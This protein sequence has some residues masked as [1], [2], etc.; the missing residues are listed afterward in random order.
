VSRRLLVF[1]FA[2]AAVFF[3]S[4]TL[5]AHHGNAV[6]D[7]TKYVSAQGTVTDWVWANPH[8][9]LKFDV[10][11]GKGNISHWVAETSNPPDMLNRGWSKHIFN[12]GEEITVI[13]MTVK[14]GQTRGRI[15]EVILPTGQKLSNEGGL[16][17]AIPIIDLK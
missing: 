8:C 1:V 13:M 4:S 10:K 11:D 14:N 17:S 15:R 2:S 16:N 12:P 7:D 5:L 3:L 6:F 9:F